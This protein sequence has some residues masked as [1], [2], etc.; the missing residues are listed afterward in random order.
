[1]LSLRTKLSAQAPFFF[2]FYSQTTERVEQQPRE[3]GKGRPQAF[4]GR[5]RLGLQN[6]LL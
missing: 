4:E 5:P 2:L 3:D 1:M 6:P